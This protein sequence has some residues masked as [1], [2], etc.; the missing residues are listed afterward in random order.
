MATSTH[1]VEVQLTDN[2]AKTVADLVK[3]LHNPQL[4]TV[5]DGAT[6]APAALIPR[7]MEL[8]SV[9]GMLGSYRERPRRRRGTASFTDLYSLIAH[10]N[11]FK[12]EHSALFAIDDR[13]APQL[14]S[15][16]NYNQAG[17]DGA[18]EFGDHRGHYHFPLSDE[19]KAWDAVNGRMLEQG[20][21][22]EFIEDRIGDVTAAPTEAADPSFAKGRS[23]GEGQRSSNLADL[24]KLL[25]GTWAGQSTLM[26]MSRGM[27]INE[28]ARV[29]QA[30]NLQTGE[31]QVQYE[32]EHKDQDGA[33]VKVPNMFLIIIPVFHNGPLYRI[34]VRLRYR[35]REGRISWAMQMYR[36]DLVFDDAFKEGCN[37]AAQATELPLFIGKPEAITS[38]A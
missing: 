37:R 15:V 5:T 11:R 35:L 38:P 18:P 25:G 7:G 17:F 1:P 10:A 12:G 29:K 26:D 16:I 24:Q 34:A 22:A 20:E 30:T 3:T 36:P 9:E 13:K 23:D 14:I 8:Q 19:W 31:V 32:T 28:A 2:I 4:V 21:F 27:K 6:S 33:P